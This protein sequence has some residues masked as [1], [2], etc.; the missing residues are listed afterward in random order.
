MYKFLLARS[1]LRHL[2]V[3]RNSFVVEDGLQLSRVLCS[4]IECTSELVDYANT[5]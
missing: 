3:L 5:S 2:S 4:G 1:L